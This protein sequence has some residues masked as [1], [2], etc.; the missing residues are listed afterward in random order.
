MH[1][2]FFF[3]YASAS[4]GKINLSTQTI[5]WSSPL[6]YNDPF[7]S[8]FGFGFNFDLA[9]Y[10]DR[11]AE[12]VMEVL[13]GD[14]PP[15]FAP[16][17]PLSDPYSILRASV[18]SFSKSDLR[19]EVDLA[20]S[21][22]IERFTAAV[23][24]E[25][26]LWRA[27]L[28]RLR[29]L[30][31]CEQNSN[32][33]LWSHYADEHKGVVFQFECIDEL[34]VPLLAAKP[35]IYADTPP[36][37]ATPEE[38]IDIMCALLPLPLAKDH[39]HELMHTKAE[40]WKEEKEWR[41]ITEARAYDQGSFEDTPFDPKEISRMFLGCRISKEDREDLLALINGPFAHVEAYQAVQ[42][43]RSFGLHFTKIG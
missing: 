40:V 39:W 4:V 2:K 14:Q 11:V 8:H 30:C 15:K 6:K 24:E 37:M 21:E 27:N 5:R 43:P 34:D 12:K 19:K 38:W 3:K 1:P 9:L 13:T 28:K 7:D 31:V 42:N 20:V 10:H 22:S 23:A 26:T 36:N 25:T 35:V 18:G 32:L 29:I 41:V 16:T 17:N 33:L